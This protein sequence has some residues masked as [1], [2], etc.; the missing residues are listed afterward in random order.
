MANIDL[1][2]LLRETE[3]IAREAGVE[4]MKYYKNPSTKVATKADGSFVTDA[5]HAA[6]K[7]VLSRLR[8]L[9][10]HIPIVSEEAAEKGVRPD[11][12]KGTFWVVDPLDGTEGFKNGTGNFSVAIALIIDGK[13][14]LGV[15]YDPVTDTM[16]SG[17]G[18]GTATKM[19]SE[20]VR[21]PLSVSTAKD[22]DIRIL[23]ND[24]SANILEVESYLKK[25]F[26]TA[27]FDSDHR[28]TNLRAMSVASGDADMTVVYP[29]RREGRTKWWD[30]APAH[31]IV[32]AAGG[33]VEGIDGKPLVYDAEDYQV[34]QLVMKGAA[35]APVSK[36]FSKK[37]A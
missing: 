25:Q 7:I 16:F 23:L 27:G 34:P 21:E 8:V 33:T 35:K 19:N 18:L 32:E 20:R 9:T 22:N 31:A 6:E 10:P 28:G 37:P 17:A 12:S 36:G 5:D 11:I 14:V 3:D 15:V 24:S 2:S 13:V 1:N 29:K 4:I 26:N 30:I